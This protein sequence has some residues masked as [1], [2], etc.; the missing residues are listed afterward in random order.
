MLNIDRRVSLVA[1]YI[2]FSCLY[3][4]CRKSTFAQPGTN[5]PMAAAPAHRRALSEGKRPQDRRLEPLK[6]YNGH[7]PFH[8]PETVAEWKQRSDS[9]RQ[10]LLVAAGLWPMPER[11]DPNAVVHGKVDR[12]EYTVER[13]ILE[14]YPGHYVTGSLYRPKQQE[15]PLPA[16]ICPYGHWKGGRFQE[17][18]LQEVRKQIEQG[19]EKY[20]IGGRYP[21]QAR[22]VQLARMGCIV[23]M[24]D[25]EGYA[26]SRQLSEDVV[27]KQKLSRPNYDGKTDWGF[28]STQAELRLLSPYGLQA[29]N[30]MCVLDWIASLAE[31][32]KSRIAVTGGSGGATQTLLM[33][34]ADDR[35]AA[36][37]AAVM[38]ST[39]MQGG[40]SCE[41]AS[42]LRVGAGNVD[43]AALFAPKPMGM[44][45]ADDWT[46]EFH[47]DG[48]P[49]L[50]ELFELL[51]AKSKVHLASLTQ[52]KHNYNYASRAAMFDW[53][54]KHLRLNVK[55]PIVEQDFVPLSQ[56]ELTV[57]NTDHPAPPSQADYERQLL[58]KMAEVAS[59]SVEALHPVDE[60]SAKE[61]L[62]M[63]RSA[64][65]VVLA[66]D[67]P[68]PR[69]V[70]CTK[71]R[72]TNH[73]DHRELI[74]LTRNLHSQTELPTI[75][76]MPSEWNGQFVLWAH[77]EGKQSLFNDEG[78]L[79]GELH[80]LLDQGFSIASADLLFQGEFLASDEE[81]S[82]ARIAEGERR[83]PQFTFGYN[84][85][86]F[87]HRTADLL[88]MTS[89]LRHFQGSPHD[90]HLVAGE[91]GGP[92]ALAA[93]AIAGKN[94]QSAVVDTQGFRFEDLGSWRD[95]DFLPGAVRYRDLPGLVA[96]SAP[97]PLAVIGEEADTMSLAESTYDALDATDQFALLGE[98]E[99]TT[100][101]RMVTWFL[102][103]QANKSSTGK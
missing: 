62:A 95:P 94:V 7:F 79:R 6:T 14:S 63:L 73:A 44:A 23:F 2:T 58:Q 34:A 49:E 92:W 45:S 32:D 77:P 87:A 80:R 4:S 15:G 70:E 41:N 68:A 89:A 33:C 18:T 69:E 31:V 16:V 19:A 97:L 64:F 3:F 1:L 78:A 13:V 100:L 65:R 40:C 67:L 101:S 75:L 88:T 35:I 55:T 81:V 10:R 38:V 43:F 28:Y 99:E 29:Y 37:F 103:N 21:L 9:V 59:D 56:A 22:C 27:H 61:L 30:S 90:V 102:E 17:E 74:G 36:A 72:E 25:L 54:N 76:L 53:F 52:F 50:L 46:R 98:Q 5:A 42:C 83:L 39:A 20:E 60:K 86:L 66:C 48:Y 47:R 93:R 82:K 85:S 24:Y 11:P 84:P 26:D 51:G 96:L 57:W 8:A 91:G 12:E 71:V